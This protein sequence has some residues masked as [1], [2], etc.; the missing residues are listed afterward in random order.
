LKVLP[1]PLGAILIY[2]F[3]L[4][5]ALPFLLAMLSL[6][7]ITPEQ[8]RLWTHFGLQLATIYVAYVCMN[9]IIQLATVIPFGQ[10]G[11]L[12]EVRLLD[13]SP[14]SLFWDIDALGYIFMGL[15]T[16]FA[17]FAIEGSGPQRWT[18][19]FFVANGAVVPLISFVYF[20]PTF[21][22]TLL[23]LGSPWVITTL[24]S[25]LTLARL[26]RNGCREATASS[27]A[28]QGPA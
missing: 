10:A 9:Y 17:S 8:N 27:P 7:Y 23:Y 26:F 15:S 24:G 20:Y 22:I 14:H 21:S 12:D 19:Y 13:Q 4:C 1:A 2:G 5:I 6:H 25:L 11:R 18:K 28:A 3:S 16:L